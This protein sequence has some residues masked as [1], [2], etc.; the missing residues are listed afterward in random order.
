M[1]A[2]ELQQVMIRISLA[3]THPSPR[4]QGGGSHLDVLLH[5]ELG[6]GLL[7]AQRGESGRSVGV[8]ALPHDLPHHT[9][10]LQTHNTTLQRGIPHFHC[11]YNTDIS[12][13]QYIGVFG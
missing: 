3:S 1:V 4:R 13:F 10:R 12:S 2:L 9:Q 6:Q 5:A 11:R 7:D 8:P